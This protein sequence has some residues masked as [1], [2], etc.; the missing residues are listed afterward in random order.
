MKNKLSKEKKGFTLI[1][2]LVVIGIIALLSSVVLASLGQAKN[3][4][5]NAKQIADYRTVIG[6][7]TQFK[8]DNGYY[9]AQASRVDSCLGNYKSGGCL[10]GVTDNTIVAPDSQV[11]SDLKKYISSYN[12]VDSPATVAQVLFNTAFSIKFNGFLVSCVDDVN[13]G[14]CHNL[15]IKFPALKN[16]N[17]CPTLM[18]DTIANVPL[19]SI[20]DYTL[21][22]VNLN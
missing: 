1:E 20:S 16:K 6:A 22:S 12:F 18:S 10:N 15:I 7:M 21:C 11:N 5:N 14:Q 19:D 4:A 2:L 3:K 8:N 9:P 17:S 13:Y